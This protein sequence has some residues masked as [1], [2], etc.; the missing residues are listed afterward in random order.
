[1]WTVSWSPNRS[2]HS[3]IYMWRATPSCSV[4]RSTSP[5]SM[6]RMHRATRLCSFVSDS[7][8]HTSISSDSPTASLRIQLCLQ[9][10]SQTWR[11]LGKLQSQCRWKPS[12]TPLQPICSSTDLRHRT[13]TRTT[14]LRNLYSTFRRW[15]NESSAVHDHWLAAVCAHHRQEQV[16]ELHSIAGRCTYIQLGRNLAHS[17][18]SLGRLSESLRRHERFHVS[19]Y[20]GH[21]RR[22][23][24]LQQQRTLT[25]YIC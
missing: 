18:A 11:M 5:T 1:M 3:W 16:S 6:H 13:R 25:G 7:T 20:H 19:G 4:S 23:V 12:T 21:H 17:Q 9:S 14:I 10:S 22:H 8:R 15:Q 24:R 2:L